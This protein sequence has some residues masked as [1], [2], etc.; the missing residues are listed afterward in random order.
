MRDSDVPELFK[1]LIQ[2]FQLFGNFAAHDQ[3]NQSNV[4]KELASALLSHANADFVFTVTRDF[5]A[6]L[7]DAG[8][9]PAGRRPGAPLRR[10]DGERASG[11]QRAGEPLPMEGHP[12]QDPLGGAPHPH[13]PAGISPR[14]RRA[15]ASGSRRPISRDRNDRAAG[16][17]SAAL[18]PLISAQPSCENSLRAGRNWRLGAESISSIAKRTGTIQRRRIV[19]WLRV[20][21][22]QPRRSSWVCC[23]GARESLLLTRFQFE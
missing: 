9:G 6:R 3:D 18:G 5:R 13:L 11:T 17:S 4:T 22:L 15:S 10:R 19:R 14:N 20:Q 7:P 1:L 21:L 12:R 2:T 16:T 8:P 23:S